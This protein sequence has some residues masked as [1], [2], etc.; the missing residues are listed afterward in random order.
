MFDRAGD[1]VSTEGMLASQGCDGVEER[2]VTDTAVLRVSQL[3]CLAFAL[4]SVSHALS[5]IAP[6]EELKCSLR[7]SFQLQL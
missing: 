4:D 7:C 3:L 2:A 6:C 1:A 5:A